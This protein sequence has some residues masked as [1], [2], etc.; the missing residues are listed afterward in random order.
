[1]LEYLSIGQIINV[2]GFRGEVKVYPLTNDMNRFKKLK[3]VYVEENNQLVKY[4]VENVKLLSNT[5]VVK[6]KGVDSEEAANR[7][8]NSYM[9]VD[10]KSAVSLP[11]D[12]YFICDLIDMDVYD[13][14]GL[15]LGNIKDVFQ[16]GSN[17]VYVVRTTG[18]DILVPALKEVVK[19]VDLKNNKMVV[20]LPEGLI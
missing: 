7:L 8:R 4:E 3:E 1:M 5:A 9:K 17:D 6:L 16:T 10:R 15:F 20:K 12:S 14:D 2:H 18:K 19:E 13:E 11:E